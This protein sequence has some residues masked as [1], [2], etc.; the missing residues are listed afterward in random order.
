MLPLKKKGLIA[1]V[2]AIA[3]AIGGL[4]IGAGVANAAP[5]KISA[6]ITLTNAQEGH[7]YAVYKLG[8]YT[9]A[10]GTAPK[11]IRSVWKLLRKRLLMP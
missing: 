9:T 5:A 6:T 4:G 8:S 3:M 1:S 11:Q 10:A 2:A 7:T